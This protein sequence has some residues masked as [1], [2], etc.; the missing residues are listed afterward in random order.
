MFVKK[1][2]D[3]SVYHIILTSCKRILLFFHS[4]E[5]SPAGGPSLSLTFA[6]RATVVLATR[7]HGTERNRNGAGTTL[8]CS[9]LKPTLGYTR[10]FAF[11]ASACTREMRAVG[12]ARRTGLG[13]GTMGIDGRKA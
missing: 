7:R 6:S 12:S 10:V 1:H 2:S 13:H 4:G 5:M 3:H 8:E 11:A 9:V